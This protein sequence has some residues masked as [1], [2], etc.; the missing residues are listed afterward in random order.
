MHG[1]DWTNKY[2]WR[3][4][5]SSHPSDPCKAHWFGVDCEIING[6]FH[7]TSLVLPHNNLWGAV[8]L[9]NQTG[10]PHLAVLDLSKDDYDDN[11]GNN[12]V[13][14]SLMFLCDLGEL[15]SV[16]LGYNNVSGVIPPCLGVGEAGEAQ[17][18]V[19][20]SQWTN[21]EHCLLHAKP[22]RDRPPGESA[23]RDTSRLLG[24]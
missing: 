8:P 16:R 21:A 13:Y 20:P 18:H 10:L 24:K 5:N 9:V 6:T 11:N 22:S 4:L 17:P 1:Y 15:K 3:T 14:G 19:Q 7:V 2:G 12:R 23:L